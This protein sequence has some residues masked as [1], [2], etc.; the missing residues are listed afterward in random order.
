MRN[1]L[2]VD[3][4]D[5]Y[6]PELVRKQI[7]GEPHSQ[8]LDSAEEILALFDRYGVKATFFVLGD[9]ARKH[10]ELVTK[11]HGAGHEIGSHGMSHRPL[12]ELTSDEMD[13]ELKD[14][15][16]LMTDILGKDVKLH[17][18]RA[19]TFSVDNRTSYAIDCLARNGYEYDTSVFPV[20]NYMY[21]VEGAP[22]SV[23]RPDREDVSRIND[24]GPLVEFPMTVCEYGKLRIPISGGFYM[25]VLPYVVFRALLR[26]VNRERPFVIYF[27]PW[28]THRETPRLKSIGL[29]DRLITYYGVRGALKK[30]ERLLQDFEFE[31]MNQVLARLAPAKAA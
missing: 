19:P 7:K 29:K 12:W 8:V 1:A 5:W 9:V 10:P 2:S 27:H 28:E 14:F 20:K 17:G 25:R 11:I 21:G 6:H 15:R 4:E 22:C 24:S 23:Y 3:L 13:Q 30:I 31:P 26:R 16:K 18:Y